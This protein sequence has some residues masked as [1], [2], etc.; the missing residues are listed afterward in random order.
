MET[1]TIIVSKELAEQI[2]VAK[3]FDDC[4]FKQATTIR[5]SNDS[6]YVDFNTNLSSSTLFKY[7]MYIAEKNNLPLPL[8]FIDLPND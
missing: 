5:L 3:L 2:E 1:T 6:F 4:P 8:N 7:G